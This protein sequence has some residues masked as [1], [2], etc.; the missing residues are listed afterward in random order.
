MTT[1]Q[2]IEA[3]VPILSQTPTAIDPAGALAEKKAQAEQL[4]HKFQ[5]LAPEGKTLSIAFQDKT[6]GDVAADHEIDMDVGFSPGK[7][8]AAKLADLPESV[9][10][11]G[12]VGVAGALG[13]VV[14]NPLTKN[15]PKGAPPSASWPDWEILNSSR[16]KSDG[17][18]VYVRG[19]L[20][21]RKIHGPG[22]IRNLVPITISLNSTH[23]SRAES[24]IKDIVEKDGIVSYSISLDYSSPPE[25][26]GRAPTETNL[27]AA[28]NRLPRAINVSAWTLEPT[29]SGSLRQATLIVSDSLP[30]LLP[31]TKIPT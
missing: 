22:D 12:G 6:P 5:P 24:K 28:E 17:A 29:A 18:R 2:I 4:K 13:P 15:G 30:L 23:Q 3:V 8:A 16:R 26:E 10:S 31:E 14:A 20:L 11:F 27:R 1:E 7:R 21:N 25:R 19:H 9:I